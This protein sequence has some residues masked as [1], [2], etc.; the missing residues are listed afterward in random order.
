MAAPDHTSGG[1]PTSVIASEFI[2]AYY[3][4]L[5]NEPSSLYAFYEEDS[6]FSRYDES[7]IQDTAAAQGQLAIHESVQSIP[8]AGC[9][10]RIETTDSHDSAFGSVIVIVTGIIVLNGQ[11]PRT[12]V[13]TF[14]LQPVVSGSPHF[15]VRN[16]IMR[17]TAKIT[18]A[19]AAAPTATATATSTPANHL[20][21]PEAAV[22]RPASPVVTPASAPSSPKKQ[23]LQAPASPQRAP[24]SPVKKVEE[25][26]HTPE[27]IVAPKSP[28]K[29]AEVA[30]VVDETPAA[31]TTAAPA[32]DKPRRERKDRP[33]REKPAAAAAAPAAA[34][35]TTEAAAPVAEAKPVEQKQA[36]PAKVAEKPKA[37]VRAAPVAP[38]RPTTWASRLFTAAK[39]GPLGL[40]KLATGTDVEP[41]ETAPVEHVNG[42]AA[43]AP[44]T[45][46]TTTAVAPAAAD[47][48]V[49]GTRPAKRPS[50][51]SAPR[52]GAPSGDRRE[53]ERDP[54]YSLWVNL[55][56]PQTTAQ[57][58]N[59]LFAPFGEMRPIRL[60]AGKNYCF[61]DYYNTQALENALRARPIKVHGQE[62]SVDKKQQPKTFNAQ[63]KPATNTATATGTEQ[64]DDDGFKSQTRFKKKTAAPAAAATSRPAS[65]TTTAAPAAKKPVNGAPAKK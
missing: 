23:A 48:Q 39:E 42:D 56:P 24:K 64:V 51:G 17:Y 60:V 27:P 57:E 16:D 43:A 18:P 62:L 14:L 52:T 35:A 19:A 30:P 3:N 49:R 41:L 33:K 11:A 4:A 61:V 47:A 38:P 15:Y 12:F 5:S 50:S 58:L 21:V 2:R 22:A 44:A 32:A 6:K 34:A 59:D 10:V 20:P 31:T 54:L 25:P 55:I 63:P 13:Q 40:A 8:Y 46:T 37:V 9:K 36:A 7:S 45:T 65:A 29:S 26:V 28:V 1:T 53:R